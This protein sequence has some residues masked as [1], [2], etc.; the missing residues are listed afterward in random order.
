MLKK[1][2][3]RYKGDKEVLKEPVEQDAKPCLKFCFKR[4]RGKSE[5]ISAKESSLIIR[6][7]Q[8]C[9]PVLQIFMGS[10]RNFTGL[11]MGGHMQ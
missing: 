8:Q 2:L 3:D 9:K 11:E 1:G 4:S 5:L 7:V 6:L 10:A